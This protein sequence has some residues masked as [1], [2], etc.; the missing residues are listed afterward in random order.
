LLNTDHITN[1]CLSCDI[2]KDQNKCSSGPFGTSTPQFNANELESLLADA[3]KT[4]NWAGSPDTA[5]GLDLCEACEIES[6]DLRGDRQNIPY[7]ED[8]HVRSEPVTMKQ[9]KDLFQAVLDCKAQTASD[10]ADNSPAGP[11]KT[12]E[13]NQDS[14]DKRI[15]ASR[16]E[17]KTVNEAYV[18][19]CPISTPAN[20]KRSWDSKAYEYKIVDSP[21]PQD[22][23]ELDEFVFVVRKRIRK[24]GRSLQ[25][26]ECLTCVQRNKRTMPSSTWILSHQSCETS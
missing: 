17:Y 3:A 8:S 13:N 18:Q 16:M 7:P 5:D 20:Y 22:V 10:G 26:F 25:L 19:D 4:R 2:K 1:L 9:L 12:A 15:L 23:S 11:E 6:E 21:P 24:Y 14:E